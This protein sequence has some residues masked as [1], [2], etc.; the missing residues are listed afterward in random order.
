M[1]KYFCDEC[2]ES[3]ILLLDLQRHKKD[4]HCPK[5]F[6]CDA[7]FTSKDALVQHLRI[8]KTS[9]EERKRFVCEYEGCN[10]RYTKVFFV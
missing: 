5:C 10:R 9:L 7:E 6:N 1:K 8:H 2:E 4:E 3:F